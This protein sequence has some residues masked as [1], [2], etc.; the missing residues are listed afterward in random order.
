MYINYEIMTL[1]QN[2][3]ISLPHFLRKKFFECT[4]ITH[5]RSILEYLNDYRIN[6]YVILL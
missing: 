3:T 6:F 2:K 4:K 5:P 1:L